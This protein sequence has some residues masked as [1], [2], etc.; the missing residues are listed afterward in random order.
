MGSAIEDE[1]QARG[2]SLGK[3][4]KILDLAG[5]TQCKGGHEASL[6]N[7]AMWG[8]IDPFDVEDVMGLVLR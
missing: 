4:P 1:S 3:A 6:D 8:I 7:Y 2:G 5:P